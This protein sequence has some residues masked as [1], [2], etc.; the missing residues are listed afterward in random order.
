M[1]CLGLGGERAGALELYDAFLRRLR[2]LGTTPDAETRALAERIR[3]A[4]TPQP[5]T[6][7][8][9]DVATRRAPL[10]AV[11]EDLGRLNALWTGCR[12]GRAAIG[13]I[14]GAPGT[15]KTRLLEEVAAP[16]RYQRGPG[17]VARAGDARP[18]RS[19]AGLPPL[20]RPG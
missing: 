3:Q 19:G 12:G 5:P 2:A 17:L 16:I 13:I 7:P 11:G 9:P 10:V 20:A 15:G 4:R 6:P 18:A 14:D 1:R 8:A